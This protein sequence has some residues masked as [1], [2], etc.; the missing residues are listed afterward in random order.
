MGSWQTSSASCPVSCLSK[1]NGASRP[2]TLEPSP[3]GLRPTAF[4]NRSACAETRS[5]PI[6]TDMIQ[7]VDLKVLDSRRA[8]R[9]FKGTVS[10]QAGLHPYNE[11]NRLMTEIAND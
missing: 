9:I 6:F 5:I 1:R 3:E 7:N 2:V 4:K 8:G 10:L 11:R